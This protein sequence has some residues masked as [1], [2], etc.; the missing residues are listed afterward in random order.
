MKRLDGQAGRAPR[1]RVQTAAEVQEVLAA[2]LE[3]VTGNPNL[4]PL[5]RASVVA[6]LCRELQVTI[7]MTTLEE[8][9]AAIEEVLKRRPSRRTPESSP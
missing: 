1:T 4:N 3:A 2:E 8:R 9:I 5:R 7:E 6:Q